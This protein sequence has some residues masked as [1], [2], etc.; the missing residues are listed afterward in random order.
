M[1]ARRT[2]LAIA[3]GLVLFA[4]WLSFQHQSIIYSEREVDGVLYQS[5]VECGTGVGMVFFGQFDPSLPGAATR[6]DCLKYAHTRILELSGLILIAGT[7]AWIG[8]K[9]GKEPPR[10]IRSELPDLPRGAPGFEGRRPTPHPTSPNPD[11]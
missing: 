9:Y 8:I 4:I 5:K 2:W 7:L 10:P 6:A 11:S 3:F 1:L